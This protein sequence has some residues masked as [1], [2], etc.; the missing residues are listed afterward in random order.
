MVEE[1]RVQSVDLDSPDGLVEVHA[2]GPSSGKQTYRARFLLDTSGRDT[3]MANR[4]GW[5]KPHKELDRAALNT[6]W[7]GGKY[8]EGIEEGLLQ[9]VYLG[10]DKKWLDLG[11]SHWS[12]SA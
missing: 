12:G 6:H 5:K 1:T 4:M 7:T 8:L 9:I 10:G 2:I 3:F 11:Y